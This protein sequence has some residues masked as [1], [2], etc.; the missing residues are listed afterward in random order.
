[1][2][3]WY[4]YT[5]S[6]NVQKVQIYK[7]NNYTKGTIIQKEQNTKGTNIQKVQMYKWYTYVTGKNVQSGTNV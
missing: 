3:N 1:M 2:Y 4:K 5:K 6:K 7:R